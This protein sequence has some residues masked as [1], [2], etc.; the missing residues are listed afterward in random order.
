M[1][2]REE[3]Y[4][5]VNMEAIAC[6]TP[7]VTFNTGGSPEM[8]NEKVDR[9][10]PVDDVNEMMSEI[11]NICTGVGDKGR[12]NGLDKLSM[13]IKFREYITLYNMRCNK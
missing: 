6:G 2:T 8:L 4:P 5:T 13:K 9:V 11:K 3:N 7:V 10:V 1:P 12:M